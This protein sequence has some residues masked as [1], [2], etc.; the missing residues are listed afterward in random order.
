MAWKGLDLRTAKRIVV[1]VIGGTITLVGVAMI[2][3]PGPAFI[4]IPLGLSILATEFIWAKRWLQ[5]IRQMA[6]RI[7]AKKPPPRP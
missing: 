6:S 7:A 1:A 3:L 4:V 2:V 5:K